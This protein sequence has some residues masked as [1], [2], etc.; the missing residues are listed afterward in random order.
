MLILTRKRGQSIYIG[1][2]ADIKIKVLGITKSEVHI[3]IDAPK[4]LNIVREELRPE[5]YLNEYEALMC[6][7]GNAPLVM[8]PT[9]TY[10]K[11]RIL[12]CKK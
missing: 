10:K 6:H 12:K 8:K 2:N 7:Y 1:E 9:I 5:I 4:E 11:K 3:G